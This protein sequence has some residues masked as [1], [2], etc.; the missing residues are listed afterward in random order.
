MIFQQMTIYGQTTRATDNYVD[1]VFDGGGEKI[2]AKTE[3]NLLLIIRFYSLANRLANGGVTFHHNTAYSHQTP[4]IRQ[5]P[6]QTRRS[7]MWKDNFIS[8]VSSF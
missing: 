1:E 3:M 6:L 5:S 2:K 4:S 7:E 8:Q